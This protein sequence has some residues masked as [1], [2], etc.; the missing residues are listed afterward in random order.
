MD[1]KSDVS[2][3]DTN[4]SS[5]ADVSL[6]VD[7]LPEVGGAPLADTTPG[8]EEV[9]VVETS[10][11]ENPSVEGPHLAAPIAESSPPVPPV[12]QKPVAQP[13]QVN[14]MNIGFGLV[15]AFALGLLLGFFGRPTM[16]ADVPIQVMVTVVP[17]SQAIAQILSDNSQNTEAVEPEE[18]AEAESPAE[19]S[20][21]SAGAEGV[22]DAGPTPTIMDF[23]MADARHWQGDEA[24][25]VTI[26]EFSDF[27]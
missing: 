4:V 18:A 11:V 20:A 25:P 5:K 15:A 24:S 6:D 8:L 23:V 22:N 21:E 12:E 13:A 1:N 26:V 2:P 16:I 17:D 9:T 14:P 27:K 10:S 7:V 19:L 3:P